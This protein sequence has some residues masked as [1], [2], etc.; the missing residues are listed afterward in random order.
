[1]K[2]RSFVWSMVA[3]ALLSAAPLHADTIFSNLGPGD[4]FDPAGFFVRGA[5]L[6]SSDIALPFPVTGTN[7]TFTSAELALGH[8]FRGTNLLNIQLTADAGGLPGAVIETITVTVPE[9]AAVV[10]ATSALMPTLLAGD[11]YWITTNAQADFEGA[12]HFASPTI[13][14]TVAGSNNGG[15]T[16]TAFPGEPE[17]AL[18]VNGDPSISAVPEPASLS[19]LGLGIAGLVGY[20]MRRRAA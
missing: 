15:A 1:M 4:S 7:Y 18:R 10:T 19:L 8:L 5:G 12:W 17:T 20:R 3:L 2:V 14:W 9:R 6:A 11:T 16:W 13:I